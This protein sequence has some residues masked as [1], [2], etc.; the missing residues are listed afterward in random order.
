MT[1][2]VLNTV[3][4]KVEVFSSARDVQAR[5]EIA[6]HKAAADPH[7]QYL[8]DA[9]LADIALSGDA[10]DLTAGTVPDARMPNWTGYN[11]ASRTAL[12]AANVPAAVDGLRLLGHATVGDG[13]GAL[14]KRAT[15]KPSHAGKIQSA[16]GTWWE[17]TAPEVYP[18]MVGGDVTAAIAVARALE[19]PL[20]L[21]VGDYTFDAAILEQTAGKLTIHGAGSRRTV[22]KATSAVPISPVEIGG[23]LLTGAISETWN[24]GNGTN[25]SVQNPSAEV[26]ADLNAAATYIVPVNDASM[27][28]VGDLVMLKQQR[29]F[30]STGQHRNSTYFGELGRVRAISLNNVESE[31]RLYFGYKHGVINSGTATAG[32]ASSITIATGLEA[33]QVD[34]CRITLTSGTGS[35]QARYINEYDSTTGVASINTIGTYA[36][37]VFDPIPDATT[38]YT[39]DC[40]TFVFVFKPAE[41][42]FSGFTIDIS[43]S[44]TSF[45]GVKVEAVSRS[46][47]RDIAV[48]GGGTSY[49][50]RFA[51]HYECDVSD[52]FILEAGED[53]H[54][55]QLSE[56]VRT[57]VSNPRS[58]STRRGGSDSGG[59]I[60][61]I[62]AVVKD[63]NLTGAINK[64]DGTTIAGPYGIGDHGHAYGRLYGPGRLD[65]F[66][67]PIILRGVGGMVRDI[68][69]VGDYEA[70]VWLLTPDGADIRGI[71]ADPFGLAK[72][73][74]RQTPL[75]GRRSFV[76]M[77]R[78]TV[79]DIVIEGNTVRGLNDGALYSDTTASWVFDCRVSLRNNILSWVEGA[80]NATEF[81]GDAASAYFDGWKLY[82]N[83]TFIP[84]GVVSK[85]DGWGGGG[86]GGNTVNQVG[87]NKWQLFIA[88]D[89][90]GKVRWPIRTDQV[91]LSV[92]IDQNV[93]RH[94]SGILVKD[95][96]TPRAAWDTNGVGYLATAPTGTSGTDGI[97]SIHFD[98]TELHIENRSG[99][100]RIFAATML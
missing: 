55:L 56:G 18:E 9:D 72:N 21:G 46:R 37:A 84:G 82:D 43:E 8:A 24:V 69:I 29:L 76:F 12:E 4:R 71:T 88:D 58:F 93:N 94:F 33:D 68:R 34:G 52:T 6:D 28:A 86:A 26:T 1:T 91:A 45:S 23:E 49:G 83:D 95:S 92:Y 31:T 42:D 89:T 81:E 64:S 99:Q 90:V 19:R 25:P 40:P 51:H 38:G 32:T 77:S 59:G 47:F 78:G 54:S 16:D 41:L 100:G 73:I 2:V 79:G 13:G 15:S 10:G 11:L 65:H 5:A 48:V 74:P 27:I 30:N 39:V 98:G 50:L 66:Q 85:Q 7:P 60:P 75:Y 35:G 97:F 3:T 17:L 36:Q 61:D 57:T 53:G 63:F 62:G 87:P 67:W 14:Y 20:R 70:A 80:T 44:T 22:L 96:A